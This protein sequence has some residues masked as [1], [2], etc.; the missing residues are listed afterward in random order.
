MKASYY[1][2]VHTGQNYNPEMYTEKAGILLNLVMDVLNSEEKM[3]EVVR[4]VPVVAHTEAEVCLEQYDAGNWQPGEGG[5][6]LVLKAVV[7]LEGTGKLEIAKGKL[8]NFLRSH[9]ANEW[10]QSL[11]IEKKAVPKEAIVQASAE[12]GEGA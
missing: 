4:G 5:W 7:D 12:W 3:R 6:E 11:K 9:E 2:G 8:S 10:G 1:I